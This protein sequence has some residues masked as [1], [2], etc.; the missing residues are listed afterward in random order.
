VFSLSP[1]VEPGR[2]F[3]FGQWSSSNSLFLLVLQIPCAFQ[4]SAV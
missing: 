1:P 2:F 3:D 4:K